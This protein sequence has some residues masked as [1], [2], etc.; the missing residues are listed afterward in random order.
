M[1]DALKLFNKWVALALGAEIGTKVDSVH[2][3]NGFPE[4]LISGRDIKLHRSNVGLC[5]FSEQN[6]T[7][8][9][10]EK[11]LR[12]WRKAVDWQ[13]KRRLRAEIV[14][15]LFVICPLE[16]IAIKR[17]TEVLRTGAP[18]VRDSKIDKRAYV[19]E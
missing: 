12:A 1:P 7:L 17:Q 15:G 14:V 11:Q 8:T 4:E 6:P 5:V 3:L 18:R 2:L 13:S 10:G 16:E 19:I 9:Q